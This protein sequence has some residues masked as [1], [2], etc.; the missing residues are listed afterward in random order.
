MIYVSKYLDKKTII[1]FYDSFFYSYLIHGIKY[2]SHS[3]VV[4]INRILI[5]QKNTLRI[6]LKFRRNILMSKKFLKIRHLASRYVIEYRFLIHF[7]RACKQDLSSQL[8]D[9]IYQTRSHAQKLFKTHLF[10]TTRRKRSMFFTGVHLFNIL[11]AQNFIP[12]PRVTSVS[13]SL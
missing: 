10:K 11:K 8:V 7:I 1:Y 2:L 6:I 4:Q 12:S 13:S 3:G 9:H 5:L